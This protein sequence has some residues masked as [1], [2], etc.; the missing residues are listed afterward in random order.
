MM[1][2]DIVY[3]QVFHDGGIREALAK[4]GSMAVTTYTAYLFIFN[5]HNVPGIIENL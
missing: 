5:N 1:M 2:I 3:T 4:L